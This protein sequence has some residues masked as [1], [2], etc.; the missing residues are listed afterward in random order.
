VIRAAAYEDWAAIREVHRAAFGADGDR[1]VRLIDELR[2]D[3]ALFV[4]YRDAFTA[5]QVHYSPPFR[6]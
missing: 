2:G 5:G 3:A 6:R 4:P 1:V